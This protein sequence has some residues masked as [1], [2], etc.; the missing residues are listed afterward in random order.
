MTKPHSPLICWAFDARIER[1]N[2]GLTVA[3]LPGFD[4]TKVSVGLPPKRADTRETRLKLMAQEKLCTWIWA[5]NRTTLYIRHPGHIL[6]YMIYMST[7]HTSLGGSNGLGIWWGNW[8][9]QKTFYLGFNPNHPPWVI[10]VP[11]VVDK[12]FLDSRLSL[13]SYFINTYLMSIL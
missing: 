3:T 2:T 7:N 4:N 8:N 10:S 6:T 13:F 12:I 5:D 11:R 1:G 9:L